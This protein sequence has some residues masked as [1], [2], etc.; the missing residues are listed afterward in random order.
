M[1][2]YV[3]VIFEIILI[4]IML[5]VITIK[6][7]IPDVRS[8]YGSSDRILNPNKCVNMIEFKVDDN[9]D[10]AILI[11]KNSKIY[12]ILFFENDSYVLYNR[13]IENNSLDL[14]LE[15]IIKILISNDF[16]KNNSLIYVIKYED[17]YYIDFVNSLKKSLNN[18][19]IDNS[20]TEL[21]GEY[22]IKARELN[23]DYN[24]SKS[25][26]LLEMDTFSKDLKD[27]SSSN[28]LNKNNY[29]T[30]SEKVYKK[31]ELYVSHNNIINM[32]KND[33]K[34]SISMINLDDNKNIYPS[35]NSWYYVKDGRVYSYIEFV[36][37]NKRYGFCYNGSIN[38]FYEG[39]CD[40]K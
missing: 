29:K 3:T 39:E 20:F 7:V 12:H 34:I 31:L 21:R 19:G 36:Q 13:N 40:I 5:I 26:I 16:L 6:D 27:S 17:D 35:S 14:G 4:I 25:D 15:K 32:D 18:Y 28:I 22:S 9:I 38:D 37:I 24:L 23:I 10:F 11:D 33:A 8:Q 1:K 30:Y 2:K